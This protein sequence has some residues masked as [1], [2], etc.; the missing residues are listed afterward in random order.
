MMK[1]NA[2]ALAVAG[3]CTAGAAQA[4]TGHWEVMTPSSPN[5]AAP[6][7]AF[8]RTHLG[9][10]S[11][12]AATRAEAAAPVAQV[13]APLSV[14]ESAP[15]RIAQDKRQPRAA[16]RAKVVSLPN[17]QTP[18]SP[19]ESGANRYTEDMQA[20]RQHVA[21][22]EQA[23]IAV[24]AANAAAEAAAVAAA[25]AEADAVAAAKAEADAAAL[26]A[27]QP[28]SVDPATTAQLDR[29]LTDPSNTP[30]QRDREAV[31]TANPALVDS[32]QSATTALRP[33]N[34]PPAS[35]APEA[36]PSGVPAPVSAAPGVPTSEAAASSLPAA[37]ARPAD[38]A[39]AGPIGASSMAAA[40]SS[41]AGSTADVSVTP[42]ASPE[43]PVAAAASPAAST[44]I[45]QRDVPAQ[46]Q[47]SAPAQ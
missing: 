11:S 38:A 10:A 5:E 1:K 35:P 8:S 13:A 45:S 33:E 43:T 19:N 12:I 9:G 16:T 2:I 21:S 36:A 17:P 41:V 37:T 27:A 15:S 46:T 23:H 47:G 6:Q 4:E 20:Y 26:A 18:W 24:A 40:S 32:R 44:S 28:P 30:P 34:I 22:V 31:A 42:A 25:K 29:L 39:I 14:D 3:L 7:L